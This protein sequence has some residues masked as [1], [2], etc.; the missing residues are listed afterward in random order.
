MGLHLHKYA[1][2]LLDMEGQLVRRKDLV[3]RL[4][5]IAA[6]IVAL[7]EALWKWDSYTPDIPPVLHIA[8]AAILLPVLYFML[9]NDYRTKL[10]GFTQAMDDLGCRLFFLDHYLDLEE[11]EVQQRLRGNALGP[12]QRA[13]D[14]ALKTG[15]T[16]NLRQRVDYFYRALPHPCCEGDRMG[17]LSILHPK[18][19][20]SWGVAIALIWMLVPGGLQLGTAHGFTWLVLLLPLYLIAAHFNARFTYELA[21]YTWL[22]LG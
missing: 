14:K 20:I 10:A 17:F 2:W 3:N 4:L 19:A 9:Q 22:R 18:T 1:D 16:Q 13:I 12:T 8:V 6:F 21:L 7:L 11:F 15:T 5:V